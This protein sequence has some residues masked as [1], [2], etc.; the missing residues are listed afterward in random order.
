MMMFVVFVVVFTRG[1]IAVVR[2]ASLVR[3]IV[4]SPRLPYGYIVSDFSLQTSTT[5]TSEAA[6]CGALLAQ[7][8]R[9]T[10]GDEDETLRDC[11]AT[12]FSVKLFAVARRRRRVSSHICGKYLSASHPPLA[13]PP[14]DPFSPRHK[15]N[16]SEGADPLVYSLFR[17][18]CDVGRCPSSF[19]GK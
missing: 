7:P 17:V 16:T 1:G 10:H 3:P 14:L 5:T 6:A 19:L 8:H 15:N 4:S 11:S 18:S 12:G 9:V 13:G 2:G